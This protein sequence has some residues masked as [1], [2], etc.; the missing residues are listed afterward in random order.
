MKVPWA[1]FK[2]IVGAKNIAMNYVETNGYYHL[3]ASDGGLSLEC[4][5]FKAPSDPSDLNDFV[6]NYKSSSNPHSQ[7]R[8]CDEATLYRLKM[9]PSGWTYQLSSTELTTSKLASLVSLDHMLAP[10]NE[11]T[12]KFYD[13]S[14]TELTTQESISASCQW[15]I[16]D[17]E[18]AFDY[19]IIAGALTVSSPPT[20]DV[21]VWVIAAPDIP[22]SYGGTRVLANGPNLRF[23]QTINTDGRVAKKMVYN[24]SLHTNKIRFK[25]NHGVG[26]ECSIMVELEYYRA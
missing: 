15:T 16:F 13:Q 17:Y 3:L 25:I 23:K 14:M 9:A 22:F 26:I 8:D 6:N 7:P 12:L 19:E 10:R 20:T 21:R 5:L 1:T 2:T 4:D 18:P 11:S 24:Q